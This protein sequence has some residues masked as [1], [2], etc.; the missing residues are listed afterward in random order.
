[1]IINPQD[2][3]LKKDIDRKTFRLTGIPRKIGGC[4]P[5][6]RFVGPFYHQVIAPKIGQFLLKPMSHGRKTFTQ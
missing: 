3:N 4:Q 5:M 6:S 1:M 2:P